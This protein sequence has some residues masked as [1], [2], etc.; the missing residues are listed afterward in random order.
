MSELLPAITSYLNRLPAGI[1]SYPEC[2]V[3]ASV[4][5]NG[6]T[7]K[8]LGPEIALPSEV[9]A[10]VDHPP[11]VSAWVPEVHFN[12]LALAIRD[13]HFDAGDLDGY[14]AWVLDQNRRLLGTPLYR[15]AFLLISPERLLTGVGRRW[16]TFRRGTELRIHQQARNEAEV[17]LLTP[18]FLQPLLVIQAMTMAFRAALERSGAR[19]PRGEGKVLSSTENAFRFTWR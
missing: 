17:R 13:T 1:A 2:S 14:L 18:P 19:D 15:A 4:F 3:K 10:L 16:A 5:R 7:S 12:V 6:I 11:V 9:R 8:P